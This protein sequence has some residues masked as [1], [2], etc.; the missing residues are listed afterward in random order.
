M[1]YQ[2]DINK[3]LKSTNKTFIENGLL[4]FEMNKISSF[5]YEVEAGLLNLSGKC[6]GY[7]CFIEIEDNNT[8]KSFCECNIGKY[9]IVCKH[10]IGILYKYNSINNNN[11]ITSKFKDQ[12][13]NL[14]FNKIMKENLY[15]LYND[16]IKINNI[17]V[18]KISTYHISL[19]IEDK[20]DQFKNMKIDDLYLLKNFLLE[21][22][23]P[24]DNLSVEIKGVL[25]KIEKLIYLNNLDIENDS[26]MFIDEKIDDF[27]LKNWN[28]NSIIKI[29]YK[30]E[31]L[32][33]NIEL[34]EKKPLIDVL[35]FK[36]NLGFSISSNLNV[37][38]NIFS[39][40]NLYIYYYYNN[41]IN[42]H[43]SK[44]DGNFDLSF[45][46]FLLFNSKNLKIAEEKIEIIKNNLIFNINVIKNFDNPFNQ[47]NVFLEYDFKKDLPFIKFESYES[48]EDKIF[49]NFKKII[50]D[51]ANITKK[52]YLK[53]KDEY[54]KTLNIFKTLNDDE[55]NININDVFKRVLKGDKINF[56]FNYTNNLLTFS[57]KNKEGIKIEKINDIIS[58]YFANKKFVNIDGHNI[59]DIQSIVNWEEFNK[60]ITTLNIDLANLDLS[61]SNEINNN[62]LFYL[63]NK[64]DD[65]L[66]KEAASEIIDKD[67]SL[68]IDEDLILTLKKYQIY[69]IKWIKKMLN[70][71]HGCILADEMGLGKSIQTIALLIDQKNSGVKKSTLIICPLT[72]VDNW[73]AEF[74]KFSNLN[75]IILNGTKN[76]RIKLID[77][78]EDNNIYITTY[79]VA[80]I[81][82]DDLSKY[83]FQNIILD[84]GHTIKNYLSKWTK[85]I[86]KLKTTNKIILSGTPI[87]NNLLELWSI[88]DFIIPEYL[89]KISSFKKIYNTPNIKQEDLDILSLQ[90]KP[91]I[92]KRTKKEQLSDLLEKDLNNIY[93]D[94]NKTER[95]EYN[96]LLASINNEFKS[97][98]NEKNFQKNKIYILSLISKLRQFCC[99]PKLVGFSDNNNTK[100]GRCLELVKEIIDKDDSNKIVIFCSFT[101][102][103]FLLEEKLNE[104][105]IFNS[106]LTGQTKKDDRLK[107]VDEFNNNNKKKVMLLSL[108]VGGVGLNLTSANYVI[109]YSPWWNY[110]S[111]EQAIDRLHRIGQKRRV[112][113]YRLLISDTIETDIEKLKIKKSNIINQTINNINY[114]DLLELINKK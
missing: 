114:F 68:N 49:S 82:V 25:E 10:I 11:I 103:L 83:S 94:I 16:I 45:N 62:N 50:I 1:H 65:K 43:I 97:K 33:K 105:G 109:H 42:L 54:E 89:A 66:L 4:Y 52:T 15:G 69:G 76:E 98:I 31:D 96:N 77:K 87:E 7:S 93:I 23:L 26:I 48:N 64:F 84:E 60:E 5:D 46:K 29:F 95:K 81:N 85:S 36:T 13:S 63:S 17:A 30:N 59:F 21:I 55:F 90:I 111:E 37:I 57:I 110:S 27:I 14:I 71:S 112:F 20:N 72:L 73:V 99:S 106:I 12:K 53:N 34:V 58:G 92:L 38:C 18:A 56:N 108:K 19:A 80:Q 107:I 40:N 28:S 101:S 24:E 100:L 8:R 75:P 74:K 44:T 79:N 102:L 61:N 6:N 91:F 47:V 113:V 86:K 88:F 78:I 51:F 104:N 67:I 35:F 3:I 2:F 9:S 39:K 22:K 41:K 32:S 70:F